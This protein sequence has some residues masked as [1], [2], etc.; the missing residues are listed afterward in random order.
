MNIAL[1]IIAGVVAAAFVA[2]GLTK[3]TQDPAALRE[4]M[5]WV[6]DYSPRQVKAIGAIEVLGAIGLILPGAT[7][8][9]PILVP[10]AAVGLALV[11]AGAVVVHIRRK[12][13]AAVL[14]PSLVLGLLSVVIAIGRFGKYKF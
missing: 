9:G 6:D 3:L 10:L 7:R 5:A 13:G 4:K 8:V 12:D 2:A 11:M 14:A 1:W